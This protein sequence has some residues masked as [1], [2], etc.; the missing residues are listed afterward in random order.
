M[1][2]EAP[3][4]AGYEDVVSAPP[5]LVAEVID[6]VLH[7]QPRPRLTHAHAASVLG[8]ELGGPFRSGRG[9]P[10]G[11]ILLDEPELHLAADIIVPNLAGWRRA[12]LP[13]LPDAA[14]LSVRPDWVCEVLS[15]S[16][17]RTDRVLKMPMYR[18]ELVPHVWLI[19]PD[20]K[21]LE[22]YRVDGANYRLIDSYAEEVPVRAEP[23]EA[24]VL[25]L[26]ALWRK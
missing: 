13:E 18:R 5:H 4:R 2:S 17:Q 9:G 23:F 12:T 8:E 15:P 3:K 25:D 21:T 16:T 11:W 7:T 10:G 24:I 20:A 6:G 19:D 14:F 1:G 22:V 26:G